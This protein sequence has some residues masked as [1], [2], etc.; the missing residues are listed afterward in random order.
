[1]FMFKWLSFIKIFL[2]NY[3]LFFRKDIFVSEYKSKNTI[4]M[5]RFALLNHGLII[6]FL[7][8]LAN[9]IYRLVSSSSLI[10]IMIDLVGSAFFFCLLVWFNITKKV[11]LISILMPSTMVILGIALLSSKHTEMTIYIWTYTIPMATVFIAGYQKGFS[12]SI[13]FYIFALWDFW[14]YYDFWKIIGW[15]YYAILRYFITSFILLELCVIADFVSCSLQDDLY[16]ISSTDSLT[17][18]KN[19][20]KIE[21]I[22][23]ESI[24]SS[25]RFNQNL[26]ICILD[27]DDFKYINDNYGHLK[28]DEVLRQISK[29]ITSNI[30]VVDKVGRWGGEEFFL[31][32]PNTDIN[33]AKKVLTRV[34]NAINSYDFGIRVTCS[35]GLGLFDK[36]K[37]QDENITKTDKALYKAKTNGKNQIY[38]AN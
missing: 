37:T 15:D 3:F 34:K 28:G 16:I 19:R 26:S 7:V 24:Q 23:T 10:K 18:L 5:L 2:K 4:T 35:Y 31:I 33:T 27:I 21:E 20:Q 1:M 30:R 22:L 12:L 29:V 11:E 13:I 9:G 25:I 14:Y 32:F 38:L 6:A 17:S 36:N 8:L